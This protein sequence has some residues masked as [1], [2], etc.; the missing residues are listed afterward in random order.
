M[1]RS[2]AAASKTTFTLLC[3]YISALWLCGWAEVEILRRF[4]GVNGADGF[5][6]PA[7]SSK[8]SIKKRP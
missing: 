5:P 2:G 8:I 6:P 4:R 7:N 3:P 1:K